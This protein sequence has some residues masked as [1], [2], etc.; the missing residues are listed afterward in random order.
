MRKC[1]ALFHSH[2]SPK[3]PRGEKHGL[4]LSCQSRR[5]LIGIPIQ[6]PLFSYQIERTRKEGD[7]AGVKKRE[8]MPNIMQDKRIKYKYKIASHTQKDPQVWDWKGRM[9]IPFKFRT[10]IMKLGNET[11]RHGFLNWCT[12]R[13]G[14]GLP[15]SSQAHLYLKLPRDCSTFPFITSNKF[16]KSQLELWVHFNSKESRFPPFLFLIFFKWIWMNLVVCIEICILAMVHLVK[17]QLGCGNS[18]A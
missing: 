17:F 5:D 4:I 15:A 2:P 10:G 1:K 8:N 7:S 3:V 14:F 16:S 9:G 13:F 6:P 18:V 11:K 12:I